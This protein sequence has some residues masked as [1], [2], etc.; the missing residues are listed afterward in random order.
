MNSANKQATMTFDRHYN[1]QMILMAH[2]A[3]VMTNDSNLA[4]CEHKFGANT[5]LNS[6]AQ[7][8]LTSNENMSQQNFIDG[9]NKFNKKVSDNLNLIASTTIKSNDYVN[10]ANI[11]SQNVISDSPKY[12][13]NNNIRNSQIYDQNVGKSYSSSNSLFRNIAEINTRNKNT[14]NESCCKKRNK[15]QMLVHKDQSKCH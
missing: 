7:L 8:S 11:L 14:S 2:M 1:N 15:N 6:I 9:L 3:S 12:N 5:Y 4:S 10:L 13:I